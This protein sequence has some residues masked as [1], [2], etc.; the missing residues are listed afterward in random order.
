MYYD[1]HRVVPF[2]YPDW[3]EMS[4]DL[5]PLCLVCHCKFADNTG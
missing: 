4:V 5:M 3:T 2:V 1:K